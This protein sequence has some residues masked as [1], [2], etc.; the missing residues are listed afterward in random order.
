MVKLYHIYIYI[1]QVTVYQNI[2]NYIKLYELYQVISTLKVQ[3]PQ[4][5]R[6]PPRGPE[7]VLRR[8]FRGI[9]SRVM[10]S[11]AE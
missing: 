7:K 4:K 11:N 1:Y 2:S 9:Y 10:P 3:R 6:S 5:A 8:E